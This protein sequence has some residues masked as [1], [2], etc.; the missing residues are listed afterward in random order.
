MFSAD[1]VSR[2]G[3]VTKLPNLIRVRAGQHFDDVIHTHA[4]TSFLADAIDA[5]QKLLRCERAVPSLARREAVV[6][7]FAVHGVARG[8]ARPT[9]NFRFNAR[10]QKLLSEVAKQKL[11][12]ATRYFR[13]VDH[14]LQLRFGDLALFRVC[15]VLDEPHLLHAV[16]RAEHQ[17]TF[18]RQPITP[19]AACLLVI[20]LDVLRQIVVDDEAHIRFVDAHAERNRRAHHAGFI[21]QKGFLVFSARGRVHPGVIRQRFDP[22]LRKFPR[23]VLGRLACETIDDARFAAS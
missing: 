1:V 16:A 13:V 3:L 19:G 10:F 9:V 4:E 23:H 17:Q 7:T 6:A 15:L 20:S 2:K 8:D 22:I 21:A 14:R 11:A 12:S 18:A 5:R